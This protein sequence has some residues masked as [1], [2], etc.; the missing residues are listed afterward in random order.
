[1]IL[2]VWNPVSQRHALFCDEGDSAWLYLTQ[3]GENGPEC[4][5]VVASVF[6]CNRVETA[7]SF[8]KLAR[9]APGPP[10]AAEG[11]AAPGA[12]YPTLEGLDW[13]IRWSLDGDSVALLQ[14]EDPVAMIVAPNFELYSRYLLKE[15]GWG[16]PWSDAV[17]RHA[18]EP[19]EG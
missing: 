6:V 18:F 3:P 19:V 13:G 2:A 12:Y 17:Y 14:G 10:P 1:M 9:W 5:P 4:P 16:L 7:P 11:Y 8:T 15:G